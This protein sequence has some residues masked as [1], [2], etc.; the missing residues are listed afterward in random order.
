MGHKN[1]CSSSVN[2]GIRSSYNLRL[3]ISLEYSRRCKATPRLNATIKKASGGHEM[4][5]HLLEVE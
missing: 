1:L 4:K 5:A 3:H 2:Y